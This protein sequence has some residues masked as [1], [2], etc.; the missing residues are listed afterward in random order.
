MRTKVISLCDET[1]QLAADM[2]NFSMWV[3]S[4]LLML[5]EGRLKMAKAADA[6]LKQH[7]SYP[8]WYS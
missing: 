2:E 3:R 4:Q 5:D 6:Y 1:W 8:E 7:G